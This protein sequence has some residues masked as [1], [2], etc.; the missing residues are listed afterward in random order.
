MA[1]ASIC[2]HFGI[3]F[4]VLLALLMLAPVP[5]LASGEDIDI[6]PNEGEIGDKVDVKGWF[7]YSGQSVYIYFSSYEAKEGDNIDSLEAYHRLKSTYAGE[8]GDPDEEEIHST[9]E[10]P[11]E[12]EHGD[13]KEMVHGGIY[14][15]YVTYSWE[16]EIVAIDTFTVIGGDINS[17]PISGPVGTEVKITGT[18]FRAHSGIT[19]TY[20]GYMVNIETGDKVSDGD[21]KFNLDIIIPASPAGVHTIGVN[22]DS[23]QEAKTEYTVKPRITVIPP[24]GA[25]GDSINTSGTGF[26]SDATVIVK[27][28]G[29][30]VAVGETDE[31]GNFEIS[32]TIPKRTPGVYEIEAE[33]EAKNNDKV[34]FNIAADIKLSKTIGSV[35]EEVTV[36]GTGFKPGSIVTVSFNNEPI[37]VS[38]TT[39]DTS[40]MF[41]A[42]FTVPM[43]NHGNNTMTV[44][45]GTNTIK[46]MFTV[47]ST[48]P[49]VPVLF[50]PRIGTKAESQVY[51][52]WE[53]IHD[54]SGVTYSLQVAI[55]DQ[56]T[57]ESILL[58][59]LGLTHSEYTITKEERL[60]PIKEE[61]PYYWRVKAVDGASNESGWATPRPFY[62]GFAF[63]MMPNWMMYALFGF[64]A[65][66][67]GVISFSLASRIRSHSKPPR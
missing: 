62:V 34:A 20:R 56:F 45:D 65:F 64:G 43:S 13:T 12:L 28:D 40:G 22:D 42:T 29:D 17:D 27:F 52:D 30:E 3:L 59:R 58:E 44:S 53:D 18:G 36:S 1:R 25:D 61:A 50:L 10:V 2:V 16:R 49:P 32:I 41:L 24:N 6:E 37:V 46:S 19:V 67:L 14:Y 60:G 8:E 39:A 4:T 55:D 66:L 9:F 23:G 26:G 7:F 54:P 31:N 35:G 38:P 11:A 15:V 63:T 48:P 51:F 57:D 33:D 47:E 21:G 5:V